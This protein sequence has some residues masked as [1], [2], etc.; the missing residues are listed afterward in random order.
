[1]HTLRHVAMVSDSN[2]ID[3]Y[4]QSN[5]DISNLVIWKTPRTRL[6]FRFPS[7]SHKEYIENSYLHYEWRKYV[8]TMGRAR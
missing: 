1:M 8:F 2:S 4:V 6:F 7:H 5:F 3:M